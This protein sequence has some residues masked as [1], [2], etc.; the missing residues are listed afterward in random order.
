MPHTPGPWIYHAPATPAA[1][2]FVTRADGY[3]VA[4]CAIAGEADAR[5][6]AAAP[7]LLAAIERLLAGLAAD[8][9]SMVR[10]SLV[11]AI[12]SGLAAIRAARRGENDG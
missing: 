5:L 12:V 6:I 3:T 9:G 1:R 2:P 7:A 10:T 4:E 8:P 11:D